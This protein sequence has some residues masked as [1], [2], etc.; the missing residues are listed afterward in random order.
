MRPTLSPRPFRSLALVA[1]TFATLA[2]TPAPAGSVISLPGPCALHRLD[3]ETVPHFSKRLIRCAVERLGPVKGG[4]DRAIC[5]ARR[6]SGLWPSATS[7]PTGEY[8]GLYQHDRDYW[9]WR[10]DH[11][12]RPAWE[13]SHRA[14]N[15]RS[16]AIVT[17]RMVAAFGS[18]NEAGWP[19]RDC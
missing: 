19:R 10:F 3:G 1:A 8:R 6:E 4:V 11:Y 17:I 7:E 2:L 18:W 16:N 12:T 9:P 5:I 14:L 15:G 13:L